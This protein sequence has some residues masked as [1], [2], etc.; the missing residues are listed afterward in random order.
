MSNKNGI[1]VILQ[2]RENK[3]RL[4]VILQLRENDST[5]PAKDPAI[6]L[7]RLW[8]HMML[9]IFQV[10]TMT[11][12]Y[13]ARQRSLPFATARLD[14]NHLCTTLHSS[15]EVHIVVLLIVVCYVVASMRTNHSSWQRPEMSVENQIDNGNKIVHF[16]F[17]NFLKQYE[18]HLCRW[19]W[20]TSLFKF[21]DFSLSGI[22]QVIYCCMN[23]KT[24]SFECFPIIGA[25]FTQL[26]DNRTSD[27][28]LFSP[29]LVTVS[30]NRSA[31][32]TMSYVVR[33]KISL[34]SCENNC[35]ECKC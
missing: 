14:Y 6:Q 35:Y 21:G 16:Q 27:T 4:F 3:N 31:N 10:T 26:A 29:V 7:S 23:S 15:I 5:V 13:I 22:E 11:L 34:S 1:F 18:P 30:F 17:L 12:R 9:H 8:L 32:P 33:V 20:F 24:S 19:N 25:E 28:S 2:L